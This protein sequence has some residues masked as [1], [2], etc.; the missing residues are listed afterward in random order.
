M[1]QKRLQKVVVI[2]GGTGS[3]VVLSG[4]RKHNLDLTAVV[5]VTDSG[6][7]TGRL[8]TEFGFL[9]V[10]DMRQCLAALAS[11]DKEDFIRK[12]LLYRF[13]KGKGLRGHNI[14][15]LILT[16]LTDL[17]S[18]EPKAIETAAKIFRLKGRIYPITTKNIELVAVYEDGKKVVG[19][20][21]IDA[22]KHQGGK[23]I[24]KLTTRPKANIYKEARKAIHQA[25]LIILGPG[26][27]FTSILPNLVINGVQKAFK[28][29]KAKLVYIVNLMTRYSQ[30]DK[31]TAKD[32]VDQIQN[33]LGT[34]LDYVLIN[35]AKIPNKI[36][37]LYK[38]EKSLSVKDDLDG[39]YI[40]KIIRK[41][42]IASEVIIKNKADLLKRSFLRHDSDKLAKTIISLLR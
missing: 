37:R 38:K 26:D 1:K 8:R 30:T 12:L 17:S 9:P 20:H 23:K 40:F 13:S 33:H 10:G 39:R 35:N 19:E 14:G 25:D 32:H 5:S 2:G 21:E 41:N 29:S 28:K 34:K 11:D 15:N 7:S 22:P 6:G 16:A 4:L 36:L 3:F 24:V 31:Y 42:F 27:L 18:S